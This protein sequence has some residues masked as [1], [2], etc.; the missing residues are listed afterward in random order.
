MRACRLVFPGCVVTYLN[1]DSMSMREVIDDLNVV[2]SL[3]I[4]REL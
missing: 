4:N 3:V 1:F 2:N